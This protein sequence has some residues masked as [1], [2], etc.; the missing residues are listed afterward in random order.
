MNNS[1]PKKLSFRVLV[2][3]W[4]FFELTRVL[5]PRWRDWGW[6]GVFYHFHGTILLSILIIRYAF[7]LLI[8][9]HLTNFKPYDPFTVLSQL[10]GVDIYLRIIF[11][12]TLIFVDGLHAV[13]DF[14]SIKECHIWEQVENLILRPQRFF[15]HYYCELSQKNATQNEKS[16]FKK[17]KDDYFGHCFDYEKMQKASKLLNINLVSKTS[18]SMTFFIIKVINRLELC[19]ILCNCFLC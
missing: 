1:K 16:L 19:V 8:V 12:F 15:L 13:Y 9:F 2:T 5:D 3:S 6:K 18:S 4:I 10:Y 14:T 17:I 11:F 7:H